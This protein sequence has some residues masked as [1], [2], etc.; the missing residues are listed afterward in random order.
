MQQQITNTFKMVP[1]WGNMELR[2]QPVQP[3]QVLR[4]RNKSLYFQATN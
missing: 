2:P 3:G 4:V 1:E